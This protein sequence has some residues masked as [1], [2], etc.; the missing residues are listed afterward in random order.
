M[1]ASTPQQPDAAR[2]VTVDHVVIRPTDAAQ[3]IEA[4][5]GDLRGIADKA[6]LAFLSY[7]LEV[8]QEEAAQQGNPANA[9]AVY[10][11]VPPQS[12]G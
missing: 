12:A 7:L 9:F 4:V 8:A 6:N 3:Y 1:R 11:E 2:D 10:G 5:C